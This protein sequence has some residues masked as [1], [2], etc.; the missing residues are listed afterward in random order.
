MIDSRSKSSWVPNSRH[1]DNFVV[2][3]SCRLKKC[4]C[5]LL[6]ASSSWQVDPNGYW[7]FGSRGTSCGRFL[8]PV[9]MPHSPAKPCK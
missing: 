3:F 9:K 6:K 8:I 7:S 5:K 1:H 2:D 4:I